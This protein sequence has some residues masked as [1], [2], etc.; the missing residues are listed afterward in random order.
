MYLTPYLPSATLELRQ[1]LS[2]TP[3]ASCGQPFKKN[4]GHGPELAN[5][6]STPWFLA[7]PFGEFPVPAARFLHIHIDLVGPLIS[8]VGFQYSL[9]AVDCFT[10]WPVAFPLPYITAETVSHALLND[11]ISRFRCPQT[12]TA[13]QGRQ[14]EL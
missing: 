3:N 4:V 14:F 8:S 7:T 12:V 9:T 5:P 6:A 1:L 11:W 13:D 2:S 10:R